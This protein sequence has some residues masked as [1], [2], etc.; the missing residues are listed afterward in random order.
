MEIQRKK[1]EVNPKRVSRK[2]ERIERRILLIN[3]KLNRHESL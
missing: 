2:Q 1:I 3:Q